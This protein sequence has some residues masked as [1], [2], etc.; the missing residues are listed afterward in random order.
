MRAAPGIWALRNSR[1]L[2]DSRL[3][4]LRARRPAQKPAPTETSSPSTTR[5]QQSH[6]MQDKLPSRA[7]AAPEMPATSAWLSLVGMP[8][9]QA[10][11]AQRT[12]EAIAAQ[13]AARAARGPPPKE[14][15]E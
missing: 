11:A 13:R 5:A 2:Q 6:R 14:A 10:A 4:A 1:S 12:M 3:S 15:M 9:H 8:N 7:A